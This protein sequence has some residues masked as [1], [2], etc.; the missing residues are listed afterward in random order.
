MLFNA[1]AYQVYMC[2]VP[3]YQMVVGSFRNL[4]RLISPYFRPAL[5]RRTPV[6]S[7]RCT[8]STNR[9]RGCSRCCTAAAEHRKRLPPG[10]NRWQ[11]SKASPAGH[12]ISYE[13][14][15]H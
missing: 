3:T 1:F 14:R 4:Y 8:G 6:D 9:P 11:T 5:P 2:V 12:Y 10:G 7:A 13:N 15:F